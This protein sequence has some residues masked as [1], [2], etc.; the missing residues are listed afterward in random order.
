MIR[1]CSMHK[2]VRYNI[3]YFDLKDLILHSAWEVYKQ[4]KVVLKWVLTETSCEAVS[5]I[6]Q[7][8]DN[9]QWWVLGIQWWVSVFHRCREVLIIQTITNSLPK[10]MRHG[11]SVVSRIL[12]KKLI[13][14]YFAIFF[15]NCWPVVFCAFW[16][17]EIWLLRS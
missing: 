16:R 1:T 13:T 11:V 3:Q 8:Q 5:W 15:L 6:Y 4:Q 17:N 14:L 12:Y 7:S 9:M 10:T 2:K